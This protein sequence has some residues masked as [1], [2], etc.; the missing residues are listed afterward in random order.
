ME[1][2][3]DRMNKLFATS[4]ISSIVMLVLGILL[5]V[6]PDFIINIVSTIIGLVIIVPK[7]V[8]SFIF[9]LHSLE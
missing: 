5:L 6:K 8:F 4:L 2:L 1:Y 3:K 7:N 9:I